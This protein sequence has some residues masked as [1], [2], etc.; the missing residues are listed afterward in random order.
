MA[1]IDTDITTGTISS[2]GTTPSVNVGKGRQI[3][4]SNSQ[5]LARSLSSVSSALGKY[6]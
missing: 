6:V 1:K 4:D 2:I 5:V 3:I